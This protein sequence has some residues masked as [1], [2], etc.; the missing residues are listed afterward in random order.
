ML[1]ALRFAAQ[2]ALVAGAVGAVGGVVAAAA[3]SAFA[4]AS[5]FALDGPEARRS[6]R[7]HLHHVASMRAWR[8]HRTKPPHDEGRIHQG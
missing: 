5:W 2:T 1:A 4:L 6:V 8:R 3:V 7:D